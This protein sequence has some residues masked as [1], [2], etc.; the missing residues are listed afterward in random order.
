MTGARLVGSPRRSAVRAA[1]ALLALPL[2][3]LLPLLPPDAARGQEIR[4]SAL[5]NAQECRVLLPV[6]GRVYAGLASGGL[7]AWETGGAGGYRHWTV[8]DG[9]GGLGVQALAW[10]GRNLWVATPGTGLTRLTPG[11]P[12]PALRQYVNL[13][14][15]DVT[16][17]AGTVRGTTEIV[18]YGLEEGGVG[19]ITGGLPGLV[20]TAQQHGLVDDR[21]RALALH[22]GALWVATAAGVSRFAANVFTTH[23]D[24][25]AD[26][27][28][29]T[30]LASGDTLLLAGATT[31]GVARWD[32]TQNRWRAVGDLAGSVRNLAVGDGAVWALLETAGDPALWR[33]DGSVW[34]PAAA[35]G[36]ATWALAGD[37]AGAVWAGGVQRESGMDFRTGRAFLARR[38]GQGWATRL[39]DE[40]LCEGIDGCAFAADGAAWLGSRL[41]LALA[42]RG[43][44]GGWT[45]IYE[46][47]SVAADSI[48]LFHH[49]ANMTSLVILPDGEVW[50]TQSVFSGPYPGGIIRVRPGDPADPADDD[51]DHLTPANSGLQDKRIVRIVRHPD[52]PLLFLSDANGVSVLLDHQRPHDPGQWVRLPT[53]AGALGGGTVRDAAVLRRD[54]VVFAVENIGL[55]RWDVNGSLAPG[56]ALTWADPADDAWSAPLSLLSGTP[57]EFRQTKALAVAADSTLWAG[58]TNGIVRVRP[59]ESGGAVLLNTVSRRNDVFVDGL[60]GDIVKDVEIDGNGD[61]WVGLDAGLN[62]LR[63]RDGRLLIDAFVSLES[64]F[65]NSLADLYTPDIIRGLPGGR[66]W[67]LAADP[68]ARRLLVGTDHGAALLEIDPRPAETP[69]DL[70]RAYLY[71]NPFPGGD[72]AASRLKVGGVTAVVTQAGALPQGGLQVEVYNLE[73]QLIYRGSHVA[74]DTG[75]WDGLNA[76]GQPVATGLYMVRVS[77]DGQSVS[78]TLAVVR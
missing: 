31:G 37:A 9:L 72:G 10:T 70:E 59:L 66:L 47:A 46:L 34:S 44:A 16:A 11:D 42:R 23:N 32:S 22:R 56:A 65:A 43:D 77:R 6:E 3:P 26:L 68:N 55:V 4:V 5:V 60:L 19:I 20:Y 35:P 78:K 63:L 2:L 12:Q 69:P 50:L 61:L 25:L 53:D 38:D 73:G 41:G 1:A 40:L 8:A 62:R 71:P 48:G 39:T 36:T 49:G 18:Y 57:Y 33:F 17:V 52:G 29:R 21:V 24:G 27:E 14:G 74:N 45:Q 15:L 7:V 54:V 75:C 28:L 76:A 64:W 51:F 67:E 13:G 58:G 30:L